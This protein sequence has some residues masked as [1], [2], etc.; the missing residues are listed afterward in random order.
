MLRLAPT[1]I[2]LGSRDLKWHAECH[3]A[4]LNREK[5]HASGSSE[6]K[7]PQESV[8][9]PNSILPDSFSHLLPAKKPTT[10]D[11]SDT[12]LIDREP[13][14]RGSRVFWDQVLADAGVPTGTQVQSVERRPR[15]TKMVHG[16]QEMARSSKGSI[17]EE[18][19]CSTESRDDTF[20]ISHSQNP[21]NE[22]K[23]ASRPN[24]R[25]SSE[26]GTSFEEEDENDELLVSNNAPGLMRQFEPPVRTSTIS[27]DSESFRRLT[28][29][30]DRAISS[31][32][33]PGD[34]DVDGSF[35]PVPAHQDHRKN[36]ASIAAVESERTTRSIAQTPRIGTCTFP[37][38]TPLPEN[39]RS[40]QVPL[41]RSVDHFHRDL[42]RSSLYISQVATS[43]SPE[44]RPR[45]SADSSGDGELS[46]DEAFVEP[47]GPSETPHRQ[48]RC[49][50]RKV[51]IFDEESVGVFGLDSLFID[52]PSLGSSS[53]S[54][55]SRHNTSPYSVPSR[56]SPRNAFSSPTLPPGDLPL[57][58][59]SATP[60]TVSSSL[61]H[62][63][64][65]TSASNPALTNFSP[66]PTPQ[67]MAI[68]NDNL[69][70]TTQPQTPARLPL[71]GL[72]TM[73]L[74]SPFGIG[75]G[76]AQTAP[77][78]IGRRREPI[79]PTTPTRRG[80]D[81]EDQENLGVA[82]EARRRR[83]RDIVSREWTWALDVDGDGDGDDEEDEGWGA[84]GDLI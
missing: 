38:R 14:P 6:V 13:V 81:I 46:S 17:E 31:H 55:S 12:A 73:T 45:A 80:R 57:H 39:P 64:T 16:S 1:Q 24:S 66:S 2:A 9:Q 63:P 84:G 47:S 8:D 77:A 29:E 18:L 3:Q 65:P 33:L 70:A 26:S 15:I 75:I 59:F 56:S 49:K 20:G 51:V 54:A 60:R 50:A 78:V 35:D 43:S 27:P 62:S 21:S 72:R 42:P 76:G 83:V 69:P 10:T 19:A 34:T 82:I 41:P 28:I 71:N 48:K 7:D 67:R 36:R 40:P 52:N 58:P 30:E 74:E 5:Q 68:Y 53:S 23:T 25:F 61:P 4:H 79:R 37:D 44:K 11:N 22:T 32:H